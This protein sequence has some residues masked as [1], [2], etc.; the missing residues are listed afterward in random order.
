VLLS[1]IE[2]N[3][4]ILNIEKILLVLYTVGVSH[5]LAEILWVTVSFVIGIRGEGLNEA[6][7]P[8]PC[9]TH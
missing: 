3:T 1:F 4:I 5:R 7:E 8:P 9:F 2:I 6:S